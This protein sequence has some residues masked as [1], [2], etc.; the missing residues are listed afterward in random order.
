MSFNHGH[1][2]LIGVGTYQ[3][4]P[5][6]DV[7]ITV[8][9]ACEVASGL[10][11]PQ[12]CGYPDEQVT[13]LHDASAIRAG[14]LSALDELVA[15][16]AE[17]DTVLLFYSGHGHYGNDDVYY[18]TSHDTRLAN[19]RVVA[20]T[21]VSQQELLT[22]LQDSLNGNKTHSPKSSSWFDGVKKFFEDMKF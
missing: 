16:T 1:A 5:H 10:R 19:G 21:A 11:D 15:R 14:I 18:L 6:L 17:G 4:F 3:H 13:L 9:D 22:K 8:A 2:L 20:G 7:A 12:Y